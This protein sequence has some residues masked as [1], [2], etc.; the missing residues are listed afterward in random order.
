M[1]RHA[2]RP[3]DICFTELTETSEDFRQTTATALS[4]VLLSA[5]DSRRF[6]IKVAC[7]VQHMAARVEIRTV[8]CSSKA[9]FYELCQCGIYSAP[10]TVGTDVSCRY[11][12]CRYVS[13]LW[14]LHRHQ[15]LEISFRSADIAISVS[16]SSCPAWQSTWDVLLRCVVCCFVTALFVVCCL[17]AIGN[18]C[19][20]RILGNF[21]LHLHKH[22]VIGRKVHFTSSV[23]LTL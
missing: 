4:P 19:N 21:T 3:S 16:Y 5:A 13:W 2:A 1:S 12:S 6:P 7:T 20:T 11:V 15:T 22:Q 9:I 18:S 14:H 8:Y 17:F 23:C 10:S